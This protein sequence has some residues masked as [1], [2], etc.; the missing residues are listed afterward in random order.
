MRTMVYINNSLSLS[1]RLPETSFKEMFNFS[2]RASS[3]PC[4][5]KKY[6]MLKYHNPVGL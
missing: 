6:E 5:A 2:S 3:M 4:H 1:N